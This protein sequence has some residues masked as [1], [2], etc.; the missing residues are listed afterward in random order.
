M[1]P[2]RHGSKFCYLYAH[3]NCMSELCSKFQSSALNTVGG[4]AETQTVLQSA[5]INICMSFK[6]DIIL[7]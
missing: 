2:S 7:Q 4:V 3:T 6:G 1:L 5:M